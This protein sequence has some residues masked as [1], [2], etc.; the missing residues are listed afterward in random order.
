MRHRADCACI[1]LKSFA[2]KN[3]EFKTISLLLVIFI[4]NRSIWK[5]R[6]I[7]IQYKVQFSIIWL[8]VRSRQDG[9]Q[10]N[11]LRLSDFWSSEENGKSEEMRNEEK[12]SNGH[13]SLFLNRNS[14][15]FLGRSA[16]A[17]CHKGIQL[18]IYSIYY[19]FT[20]NNHNNN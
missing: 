6:C 18:N 11:D 10:N 1:S 16:N 13:F 4:L 20:Y 15:F 5:D 12:Y 7:N 3:S 9:L 19:F 14:V 8:N 2:S 17:R